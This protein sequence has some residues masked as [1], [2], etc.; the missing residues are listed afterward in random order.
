[1]ESSSSNVKSAKLAYRLQKSW[2]FFLG[3][4]VKDSLSFHTIFVDRLLLR[5]L[6]TYEQWQRWLRKTI[7]TLRFVPQ[8]R[9]RT[10]IELF[11]SIF[12]LLTNYYRSVVRSSEMQVNCAEYGFYTQYMYVRSCQPSR[13]LIMRSFKNLHRTEICYPTNTK[14]A[15]F[16]KLMIATSLRSLNE[17]D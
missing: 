10:S 3:Q 6:K 15:Q 2:K 4:V 12:L 13:A 7:C 17:I 16:N 8:L 1:M 11:T 9:D 14:V 5:P